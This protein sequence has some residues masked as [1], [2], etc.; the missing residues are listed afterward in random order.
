MT[1]NL[2]INQ[3]QFSSLRV[4]AEGRESLSWFKHQHINIYFSGRKR[5]GVSGCFAIL[6]SQLSIS[7]VQFCSSKGY[8]L[9]SIMQ[10]AV[11][12]ILQQNP[13][14][15]SFKSAYVSEKSNR[16]GCRRDKPVVTFTVAESPLIRANGTSRL[17]AA[18]VT[19]KAAQCELITNQW[20]Y[21]AKRRA[22]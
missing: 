22:P 18:A 7:R 1:Y 19:I 2:F 3:K 5:K 10:A 6:N 8:L 4:P 17:S 13:K 15:G 12:V 16:G 21:T 20:W 11:V 14:K 9:R